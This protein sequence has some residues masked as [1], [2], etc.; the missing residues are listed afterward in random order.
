MKEFI[1]LTKGKLIL[2]L[3]LVLMFFLSLTQNYFTLSQTVL[4]AI[5]IA[6]VNT[7]EKC[8][9]DPYPVCQNNIC[10]DYMADCSPPVFSIIFAL[11]IA[12]ILIYLISCLTIFIYNKLK[13]K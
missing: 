3:I 5:T 7:F 2:S 8:Q 11:I 12:I 10:I 1:R 9:Q 4:N 13:T 6:I